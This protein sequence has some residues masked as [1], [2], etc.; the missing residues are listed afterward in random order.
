MCAELLPGTTEDERGESWHLVTVEGR[1]LVGGAGLIAIAERLKPTRRLGKLLRVL[2]LGGLLGLID[3]VLK[4]IRPQLGK[5]I[6]DRPG[7]YRFP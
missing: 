2:R 6:P 5:L 4:R 3:G 1:D 7:P